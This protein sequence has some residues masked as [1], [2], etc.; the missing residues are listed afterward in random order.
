M[1]PIL[2]LILTVF[3]NISALADNEGTI[4]QVN[5]RIKMTAAEALPPKDYFVD[6]GKRNGIHEGTLF[7]V[8]RRVDVVNGGTG[9]PA[10]PVQVLVGELKVISTGEYTSIARVEQQRAPSE[11]PSADSVNFL[12]GD[13]VRLKDLPK[14]I[15]NF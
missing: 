10:G 15:S 6:L 4:I 9:E 1:K 5:R 13:E 2:A 7:Q 8:Y 11:I 12:V 14:L 3:F